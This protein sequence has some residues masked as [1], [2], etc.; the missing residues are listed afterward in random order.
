NFA[1]KANNAV[2]MNNG[3]V[4]PG[5]S[6]TGDIVLA[7]N[8]DV[9]TLGDASFTGR[10][11]TICGLGGGALPVCSAAGINQV[12]AGENLV[13]G[14]NVNLN[15]S[16]DFDVTAGVSNGASS[17]AATISATN[18]NIGGTVQNITLT[19]GSD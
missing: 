17:S 8:Y 9:H 7:G 15:M 12:A 11:F 2:S 10:N 14:G 1:V 16:G 19:G 18:V 5:A 3:A 4:T 6:G 13:A